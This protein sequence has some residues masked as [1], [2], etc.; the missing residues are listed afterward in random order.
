DDRPPGARVPVSP[1]PRRVSRMVRLRP[2]FVILKSPAVVL[3]S[4]KTP[5]IWRRSHH[6]RAFAG[7]FTGLGRRRAG[8]PLTAG[9]PAPARW[10]CNPVDG[11]SRGGGLSPPALSHPAE[12]PPRG[13]P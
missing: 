10:G 9:R 7:P 11:V 3:K 5:E 1:N 8:P 13:A 2:H 4:L 6:H 12:A